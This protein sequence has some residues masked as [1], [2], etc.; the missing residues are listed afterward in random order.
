MAFL[1]TEIVG[2][3]LKNMSD[4]VSPRNLGRVLN[5]GIKA[6]AAIIDQD[7][8]GGRQWLMPGGGTQRWKDVPA[9]G[10]VPAN[11]TPLQRSGK[12]RAAYRSAAAGGGTIT[13]TVDGGKVEMHVNVPGGYAAVHRGGSGKLLGGDIVPL[14]IP[15]T[16]KMRW[17]L[18]FEKGVWLKRTTKRILIPRRPHAT[19]NPKIRGQLRYLFAQWG[20]G[21]SLP[22][23]GASA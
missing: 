1:K 4:R 23:Y 14:A 16:D 19:S 13:A 10:K 5:R 6:W 9:F 20:A 18:G 3:P 12:L 11:P 21:K 17:F 8:F 2:E 22:N 7:E 15:V